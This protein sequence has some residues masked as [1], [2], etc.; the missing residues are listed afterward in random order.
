METPLRV[1]MTGATGLI[2]SALARS[3]A[4]DG[5]AIHRL[6]R[7]PSRRGDFEFDADRGVLDEAALVG[8]DAVVHLAGEPIAQRWNER[9]R[10][11]IMESRRTGTAI[12]ASALA[13]RGAGPTVLVSASA[14]G[15]YGDAGDGTLTETSPVGDDF[16]AQVCIAWEAAAEPARAAG[17]RVVHP[18]TGVVLSAGGG[19]L[20]RLLLPFRMGLGG[21]IGTGRQWMSWISLADAVAGLRRM[22]ADPALEGP[23]N[24]VGP[25]PV[26]NADFTATLARVL[27]RPAVLRV[28]A[29]ALRLAFDDMADATLLA[30]QRA[31]PARLHAVGHRFAHPTLET[32]LR[33]ALA[34]P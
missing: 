17:I 19:A 29:F 22:I 5:H 2:G 21:P 3:L 34:K 27:G 15:I 24:L 25:Q 32:A 33:A 10:R 31:L 16:L 20:E 9:V 14:V 7:R 4:E 13:R 6:T 23:V 28:P 1:A 18:R 12:I 30:S 11:R 8:V 26:T